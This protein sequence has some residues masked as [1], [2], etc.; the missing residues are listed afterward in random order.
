MGRLRAG[1]PVIAG[2]VTVVPVE[3]CVVSPVESELGC[4][5]SGAKEPIAV[6]VREPGGARAYDLGGQEIA[7]EP[8][9]RDVPELE[10]LLQTLPR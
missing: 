1:E 6:V 3:R 10:S 8:L 7:L 2:V 4:W 5:W 9:V